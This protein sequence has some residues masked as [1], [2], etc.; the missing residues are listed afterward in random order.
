MFTSR[1]F[2]SSAAMP[3]SPPVQAASSHAQSMQ[4]GV[5][6]C[7]LH[8][9]RWY[10]EDQLRQVV[11]QMERA[12]INPAI[13]PS[14]A[15]TPH[16]SPATPVTRVISRTSTT[17][18]RT[19]SVVS[20]SRQW[21]SEARDAAQAVRRPSQRVRVATPVPTIATAKPAHR[22]IRISKRPTAAIEADWHEHISGKH[23]GMHTKALSD[24]QDAGSDSVLTAG[25][26]MRR[27]KLLE[28]ANVQ[29]WLD[30]PHSSTVMP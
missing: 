25:L 19:A 15:P 20:Q 22:P 12:A 16:C 1:A 13:L 6:G 9:P 27:V 7:C 2:H 17:M 10:Y 8:I 24:K 11:E 5:D 29:H 14:A 30:R 4:A 21:P 23:E 26:D 28:R 18:H 3:A